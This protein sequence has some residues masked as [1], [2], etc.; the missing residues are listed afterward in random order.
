MQ[1]PAPLRLAAVLTLVLLASCASANRPGHADHAERIRALDAAWKE[2]AARRDLDAMMEIYAPD[3][4]ELL[5]GMPPIVGRP[6]IRG[7][8]A[9]LIETYPRFE[10][11]F[12][13]GEILVAASGDLAVVRGTYRF[14]PDARR[15]Q[16]AQ[17][18]KFVGVWR[19]RD[20]AWRLLIN[21][22]NSD[23]PPG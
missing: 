14:T 22:S 4:R 1:G 19:R 23:Q 20:G 21:I 3:A 6:A 18:G 5:P 8:Y 2:A 10:H 11:E 16:E 13:A 9:E 17:S 15:P 12:E 7:F